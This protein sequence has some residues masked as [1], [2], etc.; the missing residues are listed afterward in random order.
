MSEESPDPSKEKI[1]IRIPEMSEESP[2]SSK[3]KVVIRHTEMSKKS[4]KVPFKPG[5]GLSNWM[6]IVRKGT[7]ISG[8][9]PRRP[10]SEDELALHNTR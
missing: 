5:R 3:E 6:S 8:I 1:V 7:N 10:V 9:T 4:L 2:E